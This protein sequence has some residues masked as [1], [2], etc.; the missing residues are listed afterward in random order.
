MLP[1]QDV[2]GHH[3]KNAIHILEL[4]AIEYRITETSAFRKKHFENCRVVRQRFDH[5]CAIMEITVS[6]F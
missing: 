2:S 3:L 6:Y 4:H 1:E 5:A